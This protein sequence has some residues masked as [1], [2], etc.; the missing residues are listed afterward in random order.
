MNERLQQ[1][2]EQAEFV[3]DRYALPEEFAEQFA[4]MIIRDFYSICD[5]A[6]Q[7][8]ELRRTQAGELSLAEQ[9]VYAGAQAQ[10]ER[11]KENIKEYFGVEE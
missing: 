1:L 8:N 5:Q 10:C 6:W 3:G 2:K 9:M 7:A 11:M 4:H